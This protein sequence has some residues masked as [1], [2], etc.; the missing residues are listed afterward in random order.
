MSAQILFWCYILT[1]FQCC[2][3]CSGYIEIIIACHKQGFP[4]ISH[5][6]PTIRAAAKSCNNKPWNCN[7]RPTWDD[8]ITTGAIDQY[9]PLW[10]GTS[11]TRWVEQTHEVTR[12][13][14]ARIWCCGESKKPRAE[15]IISQSGLRWKSCLFVKSVFVLSQSRAI[16]FKCFNFCFEGCYFLKALRGTRLKH[17]NN[18]TQASSPDWIINDCGTC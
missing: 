11:G 14:Q 9:L 7:S 13:S 5:T 2:S 12:H 10:T 3:E 1:S 8:D 16:Y 15:K 17:M 6:A 18:L 4:P